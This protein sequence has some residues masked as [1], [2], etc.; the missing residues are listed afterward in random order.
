M[1]DM[2]NHH[3]VSIVEGAGDVGAV[4]ILLRKI[5][6]ERHNRYDIQVG[7]PKNGGGRPG[8]MNRLEKFIEHSLRTPGCSAI[9]VLVDADTTCPVELA[10]TL[11]KNCAERSPNVPVAVVC[12]NRAYENW[13][14]ASIGSVKAQPGESKGII[15]AGADFEGNPDEVPDAKRQLRAWMLQGTRYRESEH[16]APLSERINIETAARVSRS[17]RRLCDAVAE[18]VTAIDS[19]FNTVTPTPGP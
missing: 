7:Q 4:P 19:G 9:L 12:A 14:L 17:F 3:I 6:S 2:M 5:L 8:L 18:L 1:S 10:R 13:F 11:T 16:Q 15:N